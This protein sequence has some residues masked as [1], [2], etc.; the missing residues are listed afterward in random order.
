MSM[1]KIVVCEKQGDADVA[2]ERLRRLGFE[3][4][5]TRQFDDVIWD[6]LQAKPQDAPLAFSDQFVVI[7]TRR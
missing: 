1:I 5:P 6:A 3:C 4:L 2:A 7:G